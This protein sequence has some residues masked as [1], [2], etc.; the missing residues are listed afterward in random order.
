MSDIESKLT[1]YTRKKNLNSNAPA[2]IICPGGGYEI[3][4]TSEGGPVAGKFA[5]NGIEAFVLNYSVGVQNPFPISMRELALSLVHIR[6]NASAYR[7]DSDKVY[8]CGFSAGGH[9]AASLS[10]NWNRDWIERYDIPKNSKPD[11]LILSYPVTG[12]ADTG[13][14]S[15][16]YNLTARLED[17]S[18]ESFVYTDRHIN[19]D[20]PDTFIWHNNDDMMVPVTTTIK[21]IEQMNKVGISFEAHIFPRGGHANPFSNEYWFHMMLKW[22]DN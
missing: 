12:K 7:I 10:V 8:V 3:V 4:G 14:S 22:L 16:F 13:S 2:V 11:K 17:E 5:E 9:L 21:F 19:V 20:M 1:R 6:E 18:L 15:S